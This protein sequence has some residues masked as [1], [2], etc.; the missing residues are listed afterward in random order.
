MTDL[1]RRPLY[2][3]GAGP[4]SYDLETVAVDCEEPIGQTCPMGFDGRSAEMSGNRPLSELLRERTVLVH[5]E[6]E[7]TGVIAGILRREADRHA[8][9]LLLRNILPAYERLEAELSA[10]SAHPVL[11]VFA[12]R[13]LSRSDR[14]R[15]DLARI[16]GAGWGRSLPALESGA[17]YADCVE[18]AAA[19]SGLR[20]VSHA[21]VRYFGDLSGGQILK[22]LLGKSLSLPAEA[23]TFYEFPGREAQTLKTEMR[24]ALDRA[25]R[26]AEDPE[27]LVLE[28]I[29][30]FEHN[31]NVSREVQEKAGAKASAPV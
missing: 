26:L 24:D 11:G 18:R 12:D 22:K 19:G 7:R 25:G 23:L 1:E 4:G 16:E 10:H 5:T 29:S 21:Y 27:I 31:I 15:H 2:D 14:L 8:Y 9:A 28:A 6:A 30:A 20:L 13:T 17:A 3:R